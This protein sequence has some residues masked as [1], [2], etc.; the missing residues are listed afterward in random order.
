MTVTPQLRFKAGI[1][2]ALLAAFALSS[3]VSLMIAFMG[4]GRERPAVSM[5]DLIQ[6][7]G[8]LFSVLAALSAIYLARKAE[9]TGSVWRT[10]WQHVPGWLAF[11]VLVLNSL[12]LIG[13]LSYVLL[14][15]VDL[16]VNDWRNHAA[17]IC[18]A[19]SSLAFAALHAAVHAAEG[20]PPHAKERW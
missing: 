3:I 8:I 11:A 12:V 15:S 18:L 7:L 16:A 19:C 13:E 5:L 20:R 4:G 10:I 17:L 2:Q 14:T 9:N 1:S 6:R